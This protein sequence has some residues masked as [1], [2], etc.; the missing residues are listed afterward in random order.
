MARKGRGVG[1]TRPSY[2]SMVMGTM[3]SLEE[4]TAATDPKLPSRGRGVTQATSGRSGAE[5]GAKST[6]GNNPCAGWPRPKPRRTR[7]QPAC[8]NIVDYCRK[9]SWRFDQ[10]S[11][12]LPR[13]SSPHPT[14]Q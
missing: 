1:E 9:R 10:M 3:R 4:Q 13:L 12:I 2:S 7:D 8:L 11:R 5:C 6:L 14:L